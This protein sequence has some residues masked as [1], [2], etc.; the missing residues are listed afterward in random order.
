MAAFYKE[1]STYLDLTRK[2]HSVVFA[3]V[4]GFG[5]RKGKKMNDK[6]RRKKKERKADGLFARISCPSV[7]LQ[8]PRA[9]PAG[10]VVVVNNAKHRNAA[11]AV[12]K[13]EENKG[14]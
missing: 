2:V 10:R 1:N 6:T 9:L 4:S 8:G 3:Q 13:V 14:L 7:F 11:A 12:I 5:A